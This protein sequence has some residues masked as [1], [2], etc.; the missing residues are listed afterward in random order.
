MEALCQSGS[1]FEVPVPDYK[2]L[3]ACRKEVC[4]L[5]ELWDMI[6]MVRG[7]HKLQGAGGGTSAPQGNVPAR[8]CPL[9]V[10]MQQVSWSLMEAPKGTPGWVTPRKHLCWSFSWYMDAHTLRPAYS[11]LLLLLLILSHISPLSQNF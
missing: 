5:K 3:K 6:V 4:L 10:K 8:S 2:Q 1:L 11:Q 7:D 9:G